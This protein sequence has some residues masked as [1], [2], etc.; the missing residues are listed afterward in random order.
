MMGCG[1]KKDIELQ[2]LKYF[3]SNTRQRWIQESWSSWKVISDSK[4]W[5]Y[6]IG[7]GRAGSIFLLLRS[8]RVSHLWFEFGKFPL[9]ITNFSIFSPS[10][11]VKKYPDQ[12]RV[13]Y[14]K[15][16]VC[17]GQ[18]K[19]RPISNVRFPLSGHEKIQ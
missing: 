14:C 15:S 3:T 17:M 6:C 7:T 11:W 8:G 5:D 18:V 10:G 4:C 12:R 2:T 13:I 16:K 9:K 1:D 19:S